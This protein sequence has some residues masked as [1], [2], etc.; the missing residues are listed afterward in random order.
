MM[1]DIMICL[2]FQNK[3]CGEMDDLNEDEAAP[4]ICNLSNERYLSNDNLSIERQRS[5]A[6]ASF[7]RQ[8]ST[9][10]STRSV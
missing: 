3:V 10:N 9:V 2:Y 1:K 4:Q 6:S 5:T 8:Q 7:G